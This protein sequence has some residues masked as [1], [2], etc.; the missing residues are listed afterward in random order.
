MHLLGKRFENKVGGSIRYPDGVVVCTPVAPATRVVTD[1][2]VIFE[3]LSESTARTDLGAK[4]REYEAAP[5]VQ[6]Y[7]ILEQDAIAG[8]QFERAENDWIGHILRAGSIL[9]M[10]EIGLEVPM[11]ELYEGLAF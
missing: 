1:P 7:V 9:H 4:N 10:P 2:V 6:R 5:S 11:A 8:T 3:V